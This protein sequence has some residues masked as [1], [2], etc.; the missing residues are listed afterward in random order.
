MPENY[1]WTPCRC[2]FPSHIC[3]KSGTHKCMEMPKDWSLSMDSTCHANGPFLTSIE[4]CME[5]C[6]IDKDCMGIQIDKHSLRLCQLVSHRNCQ[7]P[8]YGSHIDSHMLINK[9]QQAN[10]HLSSPR[11]TAFNYGLTLGLGIGLIFIIGTA[12]FIFL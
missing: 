9:K 4:A 1:K 3:G 12:L 11:D 5:A 10:K 8:T 2:T 6:T 7:K